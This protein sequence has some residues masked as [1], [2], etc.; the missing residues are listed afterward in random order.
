MIAKLKATL[1]RY[2]KAIAPV[3][4]VLA[5]PAVLALIHGTALAVVEAVLTAAAAAGVIG[6]KANAPKATSLLDGQ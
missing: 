6:S 5:Q 2:R 1:A 4:T 3:L